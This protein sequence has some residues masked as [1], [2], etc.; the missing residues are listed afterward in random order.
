MDTTQLLDTLYYQLVLGAPNQEN[1]RTNLDQIL[2]DVTDLRD[3]LD[4][5]GLEAVIEAMAGTGHDL[6]L[7]A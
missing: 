6:E 3:S 4:L 7:P 2:A 1:A 5:Y